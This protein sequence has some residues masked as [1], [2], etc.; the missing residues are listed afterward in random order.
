MKCA[1][2]PEPRTH[3]YNTRKFEDLVWRRRVCP[4]GH[5]FT[6]HER[7]VEPDQDDL[8]PVSSEETGAVP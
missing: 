5:R 3:T 1:E 4:Q 8:P 2:C 6:T 7:V